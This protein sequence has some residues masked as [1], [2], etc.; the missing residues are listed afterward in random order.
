MATLF[1]A[2][3]C[4]VGCPFLITRIYYVMR[5]YCI[6]ATFLYFNYTS[7]DAVKLAPPIIVCVLQAELEA[8]EARIHEMGAETEQKEAE[9]HRLMA[10]LKQL[11]SLQLQK[12]PET[13]T[14]EDLTADD[15]LSPT[16]SEE[17]SS[18]PQSTPKA[19]KMNNV[20]QP[21]EDEL[22]NMLPGTEVIE[23]QKLS[24]PISYHDDVMGEKKALI[25]NIENV[26][27]FVL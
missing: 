22:Q 27:V 10:E 4:I 19:T 18:A 21:E 11:Q 2:A 14:K 17:T 16:L 15:S 5:L 12:A 8:R 3:I 13:P 20:D 6:T 9:I 1:L 26:H 24:R 7:I 25:I 23:K